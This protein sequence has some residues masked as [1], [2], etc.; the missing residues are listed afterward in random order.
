MKFIKKSIAIFLSFILIFTF[1]L[2]N[3]SKAKGLNNKDYQIITNNE[4]ELVITAKKGGVK[5]IM[6]LDKENMEISLET[7]EISQDTGKK[8][9]EYKVNIENATD[10]K[11]EATFIDTETNEKYEINSDEITASF[12]WFIPIGIAI[13]EALLAHLISIGLAVT[14]SG[15][16]YI[17]YSEFKKRKRT[18]SHYMAVRKSKGLFIG[19]GLKR[20]AAV[21]RLKRGDDT[22][23]TSKNNAKSIAKAA[24]PIKKIVGPEI[25]KKGKGKHYHY[26]PISRY[27]HGKGVRMK[28]HAFYGAAR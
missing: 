28:A 20:S 19:N 1:I 18:Y 14:I 22:W 21:A 23:S 27:K 17:A 26:H 8:G 11:I 24:S 13:G 10:E 6:T 4:R 2:H 7:D 9:K 15:V 12:V 16:T 25:D 3:E 5:G